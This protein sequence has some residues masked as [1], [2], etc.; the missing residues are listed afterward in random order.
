MRINEQFNKIQ[1]EVENRRKY[2]ITKDYKKP[3][4]N[5][6]E[7]CRFL[8][9]IYFKPSEQYPKGGYALKE[10]WEQLKLNEN[11]NLDEWSSFKTLLRFIYKLKEQNK[12]KNAKIYMSKEPLPLIKDK[13][14]KELI[15]I[16]TE[17]TELVNKSL[18]F[19]IKDGNHI[20]NLDI[21]VRQYLK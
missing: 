20:V 17:F 16:G 5:K 8:A 4:S 13:T 15:Y 3:N 21:F 12:L 14:H 18:K 2:T 9:Q 11:G 1:H 7:F 10:S 19:H 6:I